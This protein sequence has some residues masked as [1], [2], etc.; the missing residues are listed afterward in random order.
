MLDLVSYVEGCFLA[1]QVAETMLHGL[2][3]DFLVDIYGL[4]VFVCGLLGV[5]T[6]NA[7][8]KPKQA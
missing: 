4:Y 1:F 8:Y 3:W 5:A 6:M 2:M 7:S